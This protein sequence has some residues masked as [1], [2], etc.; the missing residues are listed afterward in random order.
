MGPVMLWLQEISLSC[1][2]AQN[3]EAV[4]HTPGSAKGG[5]G[6][7]AHRISLEGTPAFI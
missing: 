2:H 4:R 1:H 7:T 6:N 3:C 5:P